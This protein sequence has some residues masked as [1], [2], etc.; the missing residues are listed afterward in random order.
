[1]NVTTVAKALAVLSV[2]WATLFSVAHTETEPEPTWEDIT[3]PTE[4]GITSLSPNYYPASGIVTGFDNGNDLVI[5]E[6]FEGNVWDFPGIEDWEEG[7]RVALIMDNNGTPDN[8]YDDL[9]VVWRY[10]GWVY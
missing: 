7:D 9:P 2:G 10:I 1:M 5:Y 4:T 3:L 6:D 8:I